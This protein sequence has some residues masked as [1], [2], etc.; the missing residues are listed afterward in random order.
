MNKQQILIPKGIQYLGDEK[1]KEL[2]PGFKFE[3]G[4]YN[5]EITGC[6]ATTFALKEDKMSVV[7]L[8]PRITLLKNKAEQTEDCQEVYGD[9]P[10]V[11]INDYIDR[12]RTSRKVFICTFDSSARLKRLLGDTWEG[13]HVYVDEWHV[14]LSDASFKSY[15][16]LD[17]IE[18]VMDAEHLTLLSATPC[19]DTFVERM[20]HLKDLPFY[21]M[22]W[23]E[24]EEIHMT[25]I[26]VDRPVD[27]LLK[28][29]RM[30]QHGCFPS[31]T[32]DDGTRIE[33][34]TLNG[35]LSSV[36]GIL[37]IVKQARLTPENTT[38][39][40]SENEDNKESLKKLGF[41]IGKL[42][43][44]GEKRPTFILSTSTAYMGMD[45]Y[46]TDALSVVCGNCKK[47]NTAVD[48]ETE[49]VQICGRER[50]E[51]NP[52]RKVIVFFHND[53]Q[54]K[55]HLNSRMS[56][57]E[58]KHKMSEEVNRLLNQDMS[59]DTKAF[60]RTML[61]MEQEKLVERMSYSCWKEKEGLFAIN[62]LSVLGDEYKARVQHELYQNGMV[63]RAGLDKNFKVTEDTM[64][65]TEHLKNFALKTRFADKMKT[66]CELREKQH[67][68]NND[69]DNQIN[70]MER[71]DERLQVYYD[72]LGSERIKANS[73]QEN[74]LQ[75][76]LRV[77]KCKERIR[78]ELDK[79][80][81]VG[82]EHTAQEWKAILNEI[83][84]MV[85]I[86]K[87][88]VRTHL[89]KY[90]GYNK[91]QKRTKTDQFGKRIELWKLIG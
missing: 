19:L 6:G 10:S 50:L 62:E 3:T 32:L 40:C 60:F 84:L 90:Y 1:M 29:V 78:V 38:I 61:K 24:K 86:K 21:E 74:R 14:I 80:I 49:L 26:K 9:V 89:V 51:E 48:I 12:H 65:I 59:E 13:Y 54:D 75:E 17:L 16:E 46:S 39:I 67:D 82:D 79:R 44:R 81:K 55:S 72:A 20:P 28:T 42:S 47:V 69:V 68:I 76:E 4:I 23:E 30:Y 83:Y 64:T 57:I 25:E 36:N 91:M 34:K 88:G 8:V 53:W 31:I 27:A 77:K 87:T 73:Y 56:N 22:V 52:F 15:T 43:K 5:K 66:Y 11:E 35:F 45:F 33:S 7:L 63:V 71:S 2:M 18:T 58:K 85:G 37:S 70:M 41:E